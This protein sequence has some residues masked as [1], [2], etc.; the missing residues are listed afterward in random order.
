M[1]GWFGDKG[2]HSYL[3]KEGWR[4]RKS[5]GEVSR[6]S[7]AREFREAIKYGNSQLYL[8]VILKITKEDSG[9]LSIP[10]T[11][12]RLEDLYDFKKV[13]GL[14]Y[15]EFKHNVTKME[16]KKLI[17][18]ILGY[19]LIDSGVLPRRLTSLFDN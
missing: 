15:H 16:R 4:R 18:R 7:S 2:R 3:S 13:Q 1:R 6:P 17:F 8:S 5:R 14:V 9:I 12:K 11:D 10:V 19:H